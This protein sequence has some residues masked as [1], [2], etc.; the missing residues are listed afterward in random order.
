MEDSYK[1]IDSIPQQLGLKDI[2]PLPDADSE[3]V[4]QDLEFW[5]EHL[6]EPCFAVVTAVKG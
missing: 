3:V 4:Q 5:R 1:L 2:G 6:V